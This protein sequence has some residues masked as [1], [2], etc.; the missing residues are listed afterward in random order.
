MSSVSKAAASNRREDI[1]AWGFVVAC[2]VLLLATLV[3][4][5]QG[6][7][8][9]SAAR[10]IEQIDHATG[11]GDYETGSVSGP[12]NYWIEAGRAAAAT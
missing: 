4:E 1:P 12:A 5:L 7:A 10:P 2:A 11:P 8:Q 6:A 9:H 3:S